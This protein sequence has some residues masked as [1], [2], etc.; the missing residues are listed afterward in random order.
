M[1]KK[2]FLFNGNLSAF[3]QEKGFD[4]WV[5]TNE[6]DY[7]MSRSEGREGRN[8][9]TV[10]YVGYTNPHS[11]LNFYT[12][13]EERV[14]LAN[15]IKA[16]NSFGIFEVS[17]WFKAADEASKGK[18]IRIKTHFTYA[19]K[20][21]NQV[22]R[23]DQ[24]GDLTTLGD[25]WTKAKFVCGIPSFPANKSIEQELNYVAVEFVVDGNLPINVSIADIQYNCIK[26]L[27]E[28][29]LEPKHKLL[30]QD[31]T[32]I[33]AI[34]WDV[35]YESHSAYENNKIIAEDEEYNKQN[36]TK[37]SRVTS[38]DMMMRTLSYYPFRAPYFIEYEGAQDNGDVKMSIKSCYEKTGLTYQY[39]DVMDDLKVKQ[40]PYIYGVSW[41]E[42]AKLA[43]DAGIDYFAYLYKGYNNTNFG[44]VLEPCFA[45]TALNGMLPDGRQMKMVCIMQDNHGG[46]ADLDDFET[47]EEKMASIIY[48]RRM[49][50]QAMAQSCYLDAHTENG[51]IPIMHFY[52]DEYMAIKTPDILPR[53][54][55]EAK[56]FTEYLHKKNPDKY[57]VVDDI[58]FV[59]YAGGYVRG[60]AYSDCFYCNYI[61]YDA[62]SRYSIGGLIL[63]ADREAT[64]KHIDEHFDNIHTKAEPFEVIKSLSTDDWDYEW[65]RVHRI[66]NCYD[67]KPSIWKVAYGEKYAH[68]IERI[69]DEN[70]L[71]LDSTKFMDYIP[72]VG[73]GYNITPRV[74]TRV[75]WCNDYG[76]GY[77]AFG[78]AKQQ[79]QHLKNTL[80]FMLEYKKAN[81]NTVNMI[82]MY[83]WNEHDEGGYLCPA[84][85]VDE[86][87]EPILNEDGT[88]KMDSSILDE[89]AKV[90]KEFREKEKA[91]K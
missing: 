91:C 52:T 59:A 10:N 54:V 31:K 7:V 40:H 53:Y 62:V 42:E 25:E 33:G 55:K 11:I 29:N 71:Y 36:G 35:W 2:E 4:G 37:R 45:H 14:E 8:A 76:C 17:C 75:S 9:I 63:P 60:K 61:G 73:L 1:E 3:S 84:V 81:T 27:D 86:Q 89:C 22:G 50:Y 46:I 6:G 38:P 87:G 21:G 47:N 64:A 65:T 57:R 39:E 26:K 12:T 82:N 83:A 30:P 51:D 74:K 80:E 20:N 70:K 79:A 66:E 34:R 77:L 90:I 67:T 44:Q 49:I 43:M 41:E 5:W 28:Q 18:K 69:K 24:A 19:D 13:A 23:V 48:P 32:L 15:R 56:F 72:C 88:V 58:Y 16:E 85:A 78:S 68:F